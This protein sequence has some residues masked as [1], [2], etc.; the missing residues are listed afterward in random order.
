MSTLS[1]R[2]KGGGGVG[3]GHGDDVP[4]T[5]RVPFSAAQQPGAVRVLPVVPAVASVPAQDP[6]TLMAQQQQAFINQQA[7]I[8]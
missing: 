4:S 2:M 8:M 5:V 1:G 6:Q 3:A 7:V